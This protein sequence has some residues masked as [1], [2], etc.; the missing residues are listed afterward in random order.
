M[1]KNIASIF[2]GC[3]LI[4]N[5]C[6][7]PAETGRTNAME[8][9][10]EMNPREELAQSFGILT[11][12]DK[13]CNVV[14]IGS[15]SKPTKEYWA[16]TAAHCFDGVQNIVAKSKIQWK[17]GGVSYASEIGFKRQ[18]SSTEFSADYALLKLSAEP[19]S[20][21]AFNAKKVE[22]AFRF[23]EGETPK[24]TLS[25][26]S[27]EEMVELAAADKNI[28]GPVKIFGLMAVSGGLPKMVAY[29]CTA[30]TSYI[31][32]KS[33]GGF[34]IERCSG[35]YGTSD[36]L[37]SSTSPGL[38]GALVSD[39]YGGLGVF[40]GSFET[41]TFV[42]SKLKTSS[43]PVGESGSVAGYDFLD[44]YTPSPFTTCI[45][46]RCAKSFGELCRAKKDSLDLA[47]ACAQEWVNATD[48]GSPSSKNN[49]AACGL[50]PT[51][52]DAQMR[53]NWLLVV[54]NARDRI[55]PPP[56]VLIKK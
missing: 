8:S 37:T 39:G 30:N 29:D 49:G 45:T 41:N 38:S 40:K 48:V 7:N 25:L 27:S 12:D 9:N 24:P 17:T 42:A 4:L 1:L 6:A 28:V 33:I 19:S 53:M 54:D 26:E 32:Q 10:A 31:V 35:L 51:S 56:V 15:T 55:K 52:A 36:E 11:I 43:L 13:N 3:F 20:V 47:R 2:S 18:I 44:L 50:D 14:Y 16:I 5:S 46:S 21:V 23:Y 22:A 34:E